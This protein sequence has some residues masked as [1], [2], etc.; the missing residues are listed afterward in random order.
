[1]TDSFSSSIMGS[2]PPMSVG[3]RELVGVGGSATGEIYGCMDGI[4]ALICDATSAWV[5]TYHRTTRE[6][7]PGPQ[8][9][10]QS[11]ARRHSDSDPQSAAD[12]SSSAS[13]THPRYRCRTRRGPCSKGW[14]PA[15]G[16][17]P[18]PCAS[19]PPSAGHRGRGARGG[20]G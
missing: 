20:C 6:S 5:G 15:C 4:E 7:P 8:P 19:L 12:C 18:R 11:S 10:W 14:R 17:R 3:G 16:L 1:M 13:R 2:R 9:P